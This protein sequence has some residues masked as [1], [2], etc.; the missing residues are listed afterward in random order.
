M[1][2]SFR[3]G[4]IHG[5]HL[6]MDPHKIARHYLSF[7]FWIDIMAN[8]PWEY[9]VGGFMDKASR[10]TI[11]MMKWMKLPRLL[12]LGTWRRVLDRIGGGGNAKYMSIGA[13]LFSILFC[14]H[15][16]ACTWVSTLDPCDQ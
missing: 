6:I 14:I 1:I 5:G 16:C 7:W 13:N 9:L 10:K 3:T 11:K 12:R 4:Y 8:L 15:P 2:L